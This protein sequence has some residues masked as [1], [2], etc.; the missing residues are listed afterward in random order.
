M[1]SIAVSFPPGIA[2]IQE[3]HNGTG[4]DFAAARSAEQLLIDAGFSVGRSQRGSP[5]GVLWG[6]YDIQKWRN[7]SE[8][9]REALH[10]LMTGDN[11]AGPVTVTIFSTAPD[12]AIASIGA[13]MLRE[14]AGRGP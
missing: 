13:I 12:E 6:S 4:I 1:N 8:D 2:W 3:F 14:I 10:G 11:R 5:R 9:D 7:L